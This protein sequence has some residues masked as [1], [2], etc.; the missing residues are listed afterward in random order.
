MQSLFVT[1]DQ[2]GIDVLVNVYGPAH[3][4]L[5]EVDRP[6]GPAGVE[7]VHL[8]AETAGRYRLEVRRFKPVERGSYLV[9]IEALRP[10]GPSDVLR[11]RAERE[12]WEARGWKGKTPEFWEAV[13]KLERSLLIFERLGTKDRMAEAYYRMSKGYLEK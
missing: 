10:A 9:R 5:I 3:R 11:A 4:P 2:R 12:L 1:C 13:A 8:V 7:K 6:Y